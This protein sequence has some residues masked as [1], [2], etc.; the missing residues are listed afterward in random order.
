MLGAFVRSGLPQRR[1]ESEVLLQ[2][3]AGSDTTATAL[4]ATLLYIITTPRIIGKLRAEMDAAEDV[5]ALSNPI[6]NAEAKELPYLQACIREGLRIHPPFTGLIMKRVPP[7]GDTING[8]YVPGGTSI[9]HSTWGMER[10]EIFGKDAEVFRPER[11]IDADPET[12]AQMDRT[13]EL[14][15]GYGRWGCLGKSVA[16]VELNKFFVEL[17][18]RFDMELIDPKNPWKSANHNLFFQEDMWLR[19]TEREP[20][21]SSN[22]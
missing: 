7:A 4:R 14:I 12:E 18:R 16:Y 2:I 5:G 10:N 19:V 13:V 6:T 21:Q 9:G 22:K 15:F 8:Q 3:I 1:I 20:R 11:W 17:L